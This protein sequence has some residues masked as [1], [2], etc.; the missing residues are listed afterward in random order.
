MD[1]PLIG[2]G[3]WIDLE[4]GERVQL[5]QPA[6]REALRVGYRHFD[7]ALGYGTE[8]YVLS[9]IKESKV[10]RDQI[11]LTN[12]FHS[13]PSVES[14][15]APDGYYDLV[16]L[17]SPPLN[18]FD[19]EVLDQWRR[20][21]RLLESGLVLR[22]GVSNFYEHQLERLLRLCDQ[23]NLTPPFANELEIHPYNQEYPLVDFC[24]AHGV[25]VI[26]HS[27]LGGLGSH[28]IL[29]NPLIQ[30]IAQELGSTPAQAV[31]ALTMSRG[32]AVVPRSLSPQRIQ[33]NF[34][35]VQFVPKVTEALREALR[36]IDVNF[37]MVETSIA[38][39]E[40]DRQL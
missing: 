30:Q 19:E 38:S 31:L 2:F 32:V 27:P 20:A 13:M 21:N 6:A 1:L 23:E 25:R 35:S 17:H 16:L 4:G 22:I 3:T 9:A 26:A 8:P 10:P 33:E 36:S 14:V 28:L 34:N 39:K 37:P 11:F 7:L 29:Q 18:N 24:Q 5:I 12:K 15:Q 40:A